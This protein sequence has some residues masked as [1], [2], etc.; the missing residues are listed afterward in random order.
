[1]NRTTATC[2]AG[3]RSKTTSRSRIHFQRRL[4]FRFF[5]I[6]FFNLLPQRSQRTNNITLCTP[7]PSWLNLIPQRLFTVKSSEF[8]GA[9][10]ARG[11]ATPKAFAS[12]ELS[13]GIFHH[14]DHRDHEDR[15]NTYSVHFVSF[16]VKIRFD[17]AALVRLKRM[18]G[19]SVALSMTISDTSGAT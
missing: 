19:S 18:S 10:A 17:S 7:C 2:I 12:R 9:H 4:D 15:T 13:A 1:M 3:M 5:A 11:L 14:G 16:V 6:E 8:W